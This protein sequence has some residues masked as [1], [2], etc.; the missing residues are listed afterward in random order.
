MTELFQAGRTGELRPIELADA[1]SISVLD[2]EGRGLLHEAA[3]FGRDD[4]AR[5]LVAKGI[6]I[7][8]RDCF[9]LTPLHLAALHRREE[10]ARLLLE[11]GADITLADAHG[12]QAL[13]TAVFNAR[14]DY[15]IVRLLHR[16]GADPWHVNEAGMS[17]MH[18]ARKIGDAELE[19]ILG[20]RY[21]EE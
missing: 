18:F 5:A 7:D 14:G 2:T 15:A 13:W 12:N 3:A 17:P 19:A 20:R 4:I 10:I 11:H 21:D 6:E 1:A 16:S 9:G 8:C